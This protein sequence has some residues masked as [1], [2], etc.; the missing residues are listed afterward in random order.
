[1][2]AAAETTLTIAADPRRLG[3][4]IGVTAVLHS[5]GSHVHMIV[6]GGGLS[7]DSTRWVASRSNFLVHINV[8]VPGIIAE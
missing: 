3:A 5:W 2:K 8:L 7:L 6:P 4:R 1:M